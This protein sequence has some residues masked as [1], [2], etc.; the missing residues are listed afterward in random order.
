MS[1]NQKLFELILSGFSDANISFD[2]LCHL[3]TRL[4]FQE[5]IRGSHHI[6]S[7]ANIEEIINLQSEGTKAK[8]YQVM[9]VRKLFLKY[10]LE[11]KDDSI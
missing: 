2:S 11:L 7:M 8:I 1:Q 4:G 5:R 9:Q 3:L 6:F 10:R